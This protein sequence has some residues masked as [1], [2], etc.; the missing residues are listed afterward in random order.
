MVVAC[1]PTSGSTAT[2]G[3]GGVDAAAA[4]GAGGGATS[5]ASGGNSSIGGRGTFGGGTGIGAAGLSGASS[6]T[7]AAGPSGGSSATGAVSSTGAA[8][9]AGGTGGNGAS[10][11]GTAPSSGGREPS[12]GS[13]GATETSTGGGANAGGT[14]GTGGTPD[15]GGNTGSGGASGETCSWDSAPSSSNGQLSCYWFGQGTPDNFRECPG[16]KTF[17]GY[18][19]TETGS[20]PD[21]YEY[22]CPA[23]YIQDSVE[24]ISTKHFAAFPQAFFEQGLLCGMCIEVSYQGRTIVATVV[25]ACGSCSDAGHID[26]SLSAAQAL[27]MTGWDGNPKSG[28]TWR[29]VACPTTGDIYARF[30]DYYPGQVYFQNAAFPIVSAVVTL[31][32]GEHVGTMTSAFWMFDKE[33]A[34]AEVTLTDAVGHTVTGT[35]PMDTNGGSIGAQFDLTCQ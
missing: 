3:G 18:C 14:E 28:V 21:D 20:R 33:V 7:G 35:I 6:G 13:A 9:S 29:A 27:N 5:V 1:G 16:F 11:T 10:D 8:T 34:G 26:L 4:T 12:G 24:H 23:E 30:N 31:G 22:F 2:G 25:D 32:D 15:S 19:G 17:C